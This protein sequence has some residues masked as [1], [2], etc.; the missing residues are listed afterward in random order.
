MGVFL[1]GRVTLNFI[2]RIWVKHLPT[3]RTIPALAVAGFLAGCLSSLQLFPPPPT[4]IA[5]VGTANIGRTLS[6]EITPIPTPQASPTP[7]P[8]AT[9]GPVHARTYSSVPSTPGTRVGIAAGSNLPSLSPQA[10]ASEL[11]G[12]KSLNA[13][14]V[15]YDIQWN[16][17]EP[18]PGQFYWADYDRVVQAVAASG[19]HSIV[20]LDYTPSWAAVSGCSG[21]A[22]EPNSANAYAQ[23]A[24][25][26]ASRYAPYGV[27]DW[28]IWNEPNNAGYFQPKADPAGY[29]AM[30][31]AASTAIRQIEPGATIL[32]GGLAPESSDGTNMSPP[33]FLAGVYAS[34]GRP[35]FNV[36]ADHPYTF[37]VTS[38]YP[39]SANAWGQM[40][41]M[42]AIMS[43]NGDGSKQIWITEYGSPT[44]GP[45][46]TAQT[47]S[48][49]Y[50]AWHVSEGLQAESVNDFFTASRSISWVGLV[51]WYSYKD[52]GYTPDTNENF[53]G[54]LRF[55][56]SPKPAY[57]VFQQ[58][59]SGF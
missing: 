11:T 25:A 24:A 39:N 12:I 48:Y 9:Q 55:D 22:C 19:L 5:D 59:A 44:G 21:S 56:G 46:T 10:L 33:D 35:Y 49:T 30:L 45:G 52:A 29:T 27:S 41:Q 51:L 8:A 36:V 2:R 58:D 40:S 31:A 14:W 37:P 26:V 13:S 23:F 32:T 34:G 20:I 3:E 38:L 17:V 47:N 16:N 4:T 42:H 6:A 18:N 50:G 43:A 1:R 7:A 28:E 54:L 53:F 15:R 57:S